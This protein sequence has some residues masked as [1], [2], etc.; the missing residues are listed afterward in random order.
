[1]PHLVSENP[2]VFDCPQKSLHLSLSRLN[3][4]LPRGQTHPEV[5]QGTA[6][7]HHQ[8]TD[9][10]L[11]Q[12]HPVFHNATPLDA[13]VDMLDPQPPLVERLVGQ[14]LLQGQLPTAGLLRR[15]EDRHLREREG[16]EAQIGP[17][18]AFEQKP[19]VLNFPPV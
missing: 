10:L 12:A 17:A 19:T 8:V 6:A 9:T 14:V 5:V 7:L 3:H 18:G 11:P 4:W 1:M 2:S 13:A 15:H 16:Q